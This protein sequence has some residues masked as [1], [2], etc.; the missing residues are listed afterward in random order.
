MH[1]QKKIL[2]TQVMS[3]QTGKFGLLYRESPLKDWIISW[4]KIALSK[5]ATSYLHMLCQDKH[6]NVNIFDTQFM[7]GWSDK[8]C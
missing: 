4:S 2:F 1:C 5:K 6:E 8:S 3:R 7:S